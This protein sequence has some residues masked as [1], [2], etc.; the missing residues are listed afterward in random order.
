VKSNEELSPKIGAKAYVTLGFLS[1]IWGSS[2]ILIKKSLVVFD[3]VEVGAARVCF[4]FLAFSPV[5]LIKFKQID[6]SKWKK[7]ILVG[8]FGSALPSLLFAIA[9]LKVSSSIAGILNSTTPLFTLILGILLFKQKARSHQIIGVVFGFIGALIL[10]LGDGS[11]TMY[12]NLAFGS[13]ILLATL[14]Y[15]FN[16]NSIAVWFNDTP[17]IIISAV[18]F[19]MLGPL[20]GAYLAYSDF[21]Q[22]LTTHPDGY[23]AF[24]ALA[25]LALIGTG[26][27]TIIFFKLV[28]DSSAL[29]ASSVAY[30]IPIVAVIWGIVD[31]EQFYIL[32]LMGLFSILI[33]IYLIREKKRT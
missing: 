18:S 25:F 9:Q 19:S 17:P 6:W 14:S 26:L 3:P 22:D 11:S 27:A 8:I 1:I 33:G 24:A 30:T 10:L 28:Q 4:T 16:V 32:Q 20:A 15:A 23:S 31:G 7:F 29:F 12:G 5:I 21:Y 13:L 2:F